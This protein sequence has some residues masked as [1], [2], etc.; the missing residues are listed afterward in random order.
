MHQGFVPAVHQAHSFRTAVKTADPFVAMILEGV[1]DV[2]QH[3]DGIFGHSILT[4]I[5]PAF[6][7]GSTR[8]VW[9]RPTACFGLKGNASRR[10][11]NIVIFA[12]DF[13]VGAQPQG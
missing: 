3:F 7:A 13:K 11:N 12:V 8:S 9:R 5:V 1:Q 6:A 4:M 2:I 10:R